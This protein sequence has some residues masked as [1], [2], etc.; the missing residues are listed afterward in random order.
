MEVIAAAGIEANII[1]VFKTID[2]SFIK[3]DKKYKI[4]GIAISLTAIP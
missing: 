4:P 1:T 3:R 2:L